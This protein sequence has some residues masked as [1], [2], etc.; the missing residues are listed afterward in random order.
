[1]HIIAQPE[2]NVVKHLPVFLSELE[3]KE[4]SNLSHVSLISALESCDR[5]FV[6]LASAH[7]AIGP[8]LC[9]NE[10]ALLC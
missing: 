2:W 3:N 9:G 10:N 6:H 1:M 5:M 8:P 7:K 4:Y